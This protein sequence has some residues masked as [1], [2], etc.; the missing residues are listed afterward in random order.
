MSDQTWQSAL[1]K[2]KS[3]NGRFRNDKL[4]RKLQDGARRAALI[5]G[6]QPFAVVLTC[7]DS[8]VVP[9][10]TFDVG[11]GEIFVLRVAGN[12][13]NQS[14]IASIEYAVAHVGTK[15]I[16]VMGHE[17]CGAVSAALEGGDVGNNLSHLLEL[18]APAIAEADSSDVNSVARLNAQNTA[19]RLQSESEIIGRA[20]KEE[21]V[22]VVSAFYSLESGAVD[23]DV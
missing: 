23:F 20:V 14:T 16:V 13:A 2:L 7:A 15:L 4:E 8:R 18:I 19:R 12:V 5:G 3:G 22:R 17:S 6:Q 10:L 9:E 1:S 11:L 21:G